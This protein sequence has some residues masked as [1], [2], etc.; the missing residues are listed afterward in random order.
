MSG[1]NENGKRESFTIEEI[2]MPDQ[3]VIVAV[4]E[5]FTI[6]LGAHC[7]NSDNAAIQALGHQLCQSGHLLRGTAVEN[8]QRWPKLLTLVTTDSAN[9]IDGD[10]SAAPVEETAEIPA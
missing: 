8:G 6:A 10:T 3:E 9:E 2:C 7:K 5:N 4:T 1:K